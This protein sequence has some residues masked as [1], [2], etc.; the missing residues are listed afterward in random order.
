MEEITTN[1]PAETKKFAKSLAKKLK[2]NIIALSGDLGAGKTVFAQGFAEGLGIK[3]KIISPTF[4]LM[5]QHKIPNSN[6]IFYHID[7]YRLADKN[8]IAALGLEDI[9]S[10]PKNI[11]LIEWAERLE[12]LPTD[13]VKIKIKKVSEKTR[14]INILS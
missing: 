5:R 3:D 9:F 1:S 10:D 8:Q 6:N 13:T 7:L 4:I 11:I 2:G 14:R 12:N